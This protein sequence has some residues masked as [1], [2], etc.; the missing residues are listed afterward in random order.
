MAEVR[1]PEWFKEA[2]SGACAASGGKAAPR[3]FIDKNLENF[4]GFMR[5]VM[6]AE[7]YSKRRGLLQMVAPRARIAGVFFLIAAAA[8][9]VDI[10]SL[11]AAVF[12]TASLTVLSGVGFTA[13][14]KRVWPSVVFTLI[15]ISPVFFG[16]FT[17]G[18]RLFGVSLGPL[19]FEVT[20]EGVSNGL[21]FVTRVASMVS[22]AALLFLTTGQTEFFRGLTGLPLPR[23]FVTA[24]FMM[25]RFI[26][27]LLKVAEDSSLARRSRTI[28][29]V[30]IKESQE[31]FSSRV[32]LL[33]KKSLNTAEEVN[34]AMASR[35]F[36]GK[37]KTLKDAGLGARDYIWLGST[38]FLLF[39]SFGLSS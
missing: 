35:G 10:Y 18:E 30:R 26:F 3:S 13:L 38:L 19:G 5:E 23:F 39:L 29:G 16:F 34:M 17:P 25:F 11:A 7:G 22:L 15:L 1:L 8:F 31:W 6:E 20:R 2:R 27:I 21:F 24:L 12:L 9:S 37:I 28:G 32:A 33:L 14:A 36:N 4:S